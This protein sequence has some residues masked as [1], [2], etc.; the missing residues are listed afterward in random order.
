MKAL[1]VIDMQKDFTT[2]VLGNPQTAAVV[3]PVAEE[4]RR[5]RAEEPDGLV[6]ATLDT[7]F[8][9]YLNTQEGKFLPVP[10]CIKD[11]DGWELCPEVRDALGENAIYVEKNTFG[12]IGLPELFTDPETFPL[13]E[14]RVIGVCTDICVISNA[15]ILKAAFP[16]VPVK[17]IQGCCAGVTP[18]SHENAL[19]AMQA[20]QM[21]V[22]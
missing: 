8:P 1:I 7:H 21:I 13:D 9:D 22:E 5:F 12:A 3:E 16:E 20:C 18:E 10:H 15:M 2:G 17:I 4:I 11:S 6:I 14:I 19:R